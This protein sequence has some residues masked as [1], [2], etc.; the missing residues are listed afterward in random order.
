MAVKAKK[1]VD[2]FKKKK[3]FSVI[4]PRVFEG[5]EVGETPAEKSSL[6]IG[7]VIR[8]PGDEITGQRKLRHFTVKLKVKEVKELKA[9]TE[10]IGFEV[11]HSYLRRMIRRRISKIMAVTTGTTKDK[12]KARITTVAISSGKLEKRKEKAIRKIITETIAEEIPKKDFEVLV[13]EMIFG[14]TSSKI[15]KKTSN[16]NR[17]RKLEITKARLM[18]GK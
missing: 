10:V 13:H 1:T 17:L 16:I 5:K 6:V 11:N 2:K 14:I 12:K 7:R 3:W 15:F 4:A 18:E 9:F 8:T